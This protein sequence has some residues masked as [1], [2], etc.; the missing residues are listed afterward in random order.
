MGGRIAMTGQ[1]QVT[2]QLT[3]RPPA[4]HGA[5]N[6]TDI[7]IRTLFRTEVL[8]IQDVR[9]LGSVVG[10]S[11]EEWPAGYEI[12]FPRAGTFVRHGADGVHVADATQVL[13]FH[14]GQSYEIA[15]PVH[16]GDRCTVFELSRSVLVEVLGS[17][18]PD[19]DELQERPFRT[20]SAL[21]D[22]RQRLAQHRLLR[23]VEDGWL[24]D[25]IEL[26]E[27][28]LKHID[29]AVTNAYARDGRAIGEA[30]RET[31]HAHAELAS[32]VK[33]YLGER[34]ADRIRLS[35]VASAVGSSPYHMCR[36]FK[37]QA[38][39]PIHRYLRRLRLLHALDRLS[40]D[41]NELLTRTALDVGFSS[42]AHMSTAFRAEFGTTFA[43][44]R[45]GMTGRRMREMRKIVEA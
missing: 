14:P 28:V 30:K 26:E 32:D 22:A 24:G 2:R 15:H 12:V 10:R 36:I 19:V 37:R 7:N 4:S 18:D 11:D 45:R 21:V 35:E 23:L 29:L 34:M 3:E 8:S 6:I 33:L 42:H 1:L 38:G 9:C 39:L 13:F 31:R 25:P 43:E 5:I 40:D 41:P 17:Y 20:G 44:V 16:G 27:S